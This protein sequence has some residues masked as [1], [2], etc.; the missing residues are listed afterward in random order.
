MIVDHQPVR[1]EAAGPDA[2]AVAGS[3]GEAGQAPA[4]APAGVSGGARR[5]RPVRWQRAARLGIAAGLALFAAFLVTG[6]RERR[7]S[8]EARAVDR[9]D[10]EAVSQSAG[11]E[12]VR[13]DGEVVIFRLT[14]PWQSTY[15]DG[16]MRFFGGVAV[17]VP[18]RG[19]RD[20]F[21]MSASELSVEEGQGDFTVSGDVRMADADGSTAQTG[22][23]SYSEA[24]NVVAMHD[25]AGPTKLVRAG[26]EAVGNEVVQDRERQIIILD[27][28]AG[29]RLTG[30]PD[31][32][33]VDIDAP[34]VTLADAD[35]YMRFD[36]GTRI[37]TGDM[38][39]VAEVATA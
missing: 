38:T 4:T 27:G 13:S 11:I 10:P 22:E 3:A 34:H 6:M 7:D 24:R 35:R 33:A 21:T 29:V 18:S 31:R 32:A 17:T 15:A 28:A 1:S 19:D 16:S 37:R 36:G 30:D 2:P 9:A 14:A 12:F 39:I 8:T 5:R 26:L 23:A 20:G 25:P